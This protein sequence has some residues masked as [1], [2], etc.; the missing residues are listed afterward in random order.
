ME[1]SHSAPILHAIAMAQASD[2][3]LDLSTTASELEVSD[4]DLRQRIDASNTSDSRSQASTRVF[5][6]SCS[7][8]DANISSSP[9]RS[10][11]RSSPS[12]PTSSTTFT[13]G[14]LF[15]AAASSWSTSFRAALLTDAG[16]EHAKEIVP[17]AFAP[18]ADDRLALDS[19]RHPSRSPPA[20]P[21][22]ALEDVSP[23]RSSRSRSFRK[24]ASGSKWSTTRTCSLN[25][26]ASE[27]SQCRAFEAVW[28]GLTDC[29]AGRRRGRPAAARPPRSG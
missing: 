9:A 6:P 5:I 13:L 11:T 14:A 28:L 8:P 12:C 10:T 7:T 4:S 29:H 15:F 18:A 16:V 27:P 20:C 26:E 23:T 3:P 19:S 21:T 1:F 2:E 24:P 25:A 22:V 17:S